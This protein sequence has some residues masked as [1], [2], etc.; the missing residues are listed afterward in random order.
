[1]RRIAKYGTPFLAIVGC[2]SGLWSAVTLWD[3]EKFGQF[4]SKHGAVAESFSNQIDS[5]TKRNDVDEVE[6]LR[7]DFESFEENW[8][9]SQS[10]VDIVAAAIFQPPDEIDLDIRESVAAWLGGIEAH[11][12]WGLAYNPADIGNAWFVAGRYDK[13]IDGYRMALAAKVDDPAFL[14][15]Q[16]RAYYYLAEYTVDSAQSLVLNDRA[17]EIAIDAI[18]MTGTAPFPAVTLT[19]QTF[20]AFLADVVEKETPKNRLK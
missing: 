12:Q 5:A 1:M 3:S 19:D 8:R 9:Q 15:S 4:I 2:I 16:A 7:I 18:D 11:P 10:I 17:R 20:G 13:A 14:F 6:R